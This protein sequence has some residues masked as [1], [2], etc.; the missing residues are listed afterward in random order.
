MD[1]SR[2]YHRSGRL[3]SGRD[4]RSAS[5]FLEQELLPGTLLQVIVNGASVDAL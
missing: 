3:K 5:E 4:Q 2:V 1:S